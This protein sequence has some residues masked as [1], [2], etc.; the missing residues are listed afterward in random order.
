MDKHNHKSG[1][2]YNWR[3]CNDGELDCNGNINIPDLEVI[4]L[5]LACPTSHEDSIANPFQIPLSH[6]YGP[7]GLRGREGE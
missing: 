3:Q 4:Y 1:I 2:S 7:F 6:F 5:G